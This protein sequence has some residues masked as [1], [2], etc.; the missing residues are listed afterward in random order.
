MK[1]SLNKKYIRI[2]IV[3]FVVIA[4]SLIFAHI[5][6]TFDT[7]PNYFSNFIKIL[8]PIIYGIVFAYLFNPIVNFFERELIF[9]E[10]MR[11]KKSISEKSRKVTRIISVIL[12]YF[13]I[14]LFIYG[15]ISLIAPKIAESINLLIYQLPNYF[16]SLQEMYNKYSAVI[17]Q[18]YNEFEPTINNTLSFLGMTTDGMKDWFNDVLPEAQGWVD[19]ISSGLKSMLVS[20]WNV[21]IGL[22]VSIYVLLTKEKFSAQAKKI[23]YAFFNTEKANNILKDTRFVS[24]TFIGFVSGKIVDSLIIGILCFIGLS[25]LRIPYTVLISVIIGITNIIPFFGPFIGAV[26]SAFLLLMINPLICLR[27][28]IFVVI[29]QQ[30]DGNIIGPK[31]LGDST[32]LSGFWVIF[33]ITVFGGLWGVLGM[34][35]GIPFFAV[36]YALLKRKIDSRLADKNMP[37]STEYYMPIK[38]I[39]EEGYVVRLAESDDSFYIRD[40]DISIARIKTSFEMLIL[41]I[42]NCFKKK[43]K[44]DDVPEIENSEETSS[45]QT[46]E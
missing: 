8:Q 12:T 30:I 25:I 15:V 36:I 37:I 39:D 18:K 41:R 19:G 5:I 6:S 34:F 9:P 31:I 22:I 38:R 17:I 7:I 3:A 4:L 29:L 44:K 33:S 32:G 16:E 46:E 26:P 27:F 43:E 13:C 11:R 10:I 28:I 2:G 35:I 23:I 45:N 42:K 20:L 24:D 14:I 1:F 21:V 40:N